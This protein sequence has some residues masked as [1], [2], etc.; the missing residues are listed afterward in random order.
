MNVTSLFGQLGISTERRRIPIADAMQELVK[1]TTI[2][3]ADI[4]VGAALNNNEGAQ[5]ITIQCETALNAP[6][7]SV[8]VYYYVKETG[9]S[10]VLQLTASGTNLL[11]TATQDLL[12]GF[13]IHTIRLATFG[14][15]LVNTSNSVY[16]HLLPA[17]DAHSDWL[18]YELSTTPP[19]ATAYVK[20]N[21]VQTQTTAI[22]EST[23]V[24]TPGYQGQLAFLYG[25]PYVCARTRLDTFNRFWKQI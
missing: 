18:Y 1:S 11:L 2:T 20:F 9:V 5:G 6:S 17:L 10:R 13:R 21:A 24:G 15:D 22:T 3:E 16:T 12:T 23:L 14:N 25:V 4:A 8:S 7:G 19:A